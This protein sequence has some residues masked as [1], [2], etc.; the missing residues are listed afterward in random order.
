MHILHSFDF[1]YDREKN[2][3][4]DNVISKLSFSISLDKKELLSI[5][6]L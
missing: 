6:G 3:R 4:C 5:A 2:D 1:G